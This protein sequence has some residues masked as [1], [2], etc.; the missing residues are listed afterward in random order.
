MEIYL[1]GL[2]MHNQVG[3]KRQKKNDIFTKLRNFGK[4][5]KKIKGWNTGVGNDKISVEIY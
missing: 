5:R 2:V 4:V 1:M 3:C